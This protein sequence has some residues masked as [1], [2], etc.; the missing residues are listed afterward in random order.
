[1]PNSSAQKECVPRNLL[2]CDE[3]VEI[4]LGRWERALWELR[5]YLAAPLVTICVFQRRRLE[6][7][8]LWCV[9]GPHGVLQATRTAVMELSDERA[10]HKGTGAQGVSVLLL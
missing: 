2:L 4:L 5:R 8:R 1:M 9:V 3:A 7:A 6:S 10:V